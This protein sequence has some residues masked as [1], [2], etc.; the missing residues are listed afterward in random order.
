MLHILITIFKVS[1]SGLK[2]MC[3]FSSIVLN[4]TL[5][6]CKVIFLLSAHSSSVVGYIMG[7]KVQCNNTLCEYHD[8]YCSC[9]WTNS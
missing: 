3:T 9:S 4:I 6:T 7:Y 1:E 5:C 2:D 8:C